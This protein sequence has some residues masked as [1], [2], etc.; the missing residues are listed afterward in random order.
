MYTDHIPPTVPQ[1]K[2][3]KQQRVLQGT[4]SLTPKEHNTCSLQRLLLFVQDWPR[5]WLYSRQATADSV[6][7]SGLHWLTPLWTYRD[8]EVRAHSI[9]YQIEIPDGKFFSGANKSQNN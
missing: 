8:T 6:G 9:W 3:A 7:E 4:C 5:N 2:D 1:R